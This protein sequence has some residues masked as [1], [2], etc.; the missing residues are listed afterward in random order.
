MEGW[1]E[2]V[3][4]GDVRWWGGMECSGGVRGGHG[5]Q[6]WWCILTIPAL[7]EVKAGSSGIQGHPP[8]KL[9]WDTRP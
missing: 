6:V 7:D 4:S 3:W 8:L 2:V 9:A 1:G 5:S